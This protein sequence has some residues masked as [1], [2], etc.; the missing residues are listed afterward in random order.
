M[1][2][3]KAIAR[4]VA[5]HEKTAATIGDLNAKVDALQE[6]ITALT[7]KIDSLLPEPTEAEAKALAKPSAPAR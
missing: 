7:A 3:T 6:Q 5:A 4:Q 1:K 2:N